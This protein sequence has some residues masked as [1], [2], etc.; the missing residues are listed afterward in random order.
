VGAVAIDE[1]GN[2][3]AG[4]STGGITGKLTGRVG[5]APLVGLGTYADNL[6]GGISATG[7]LVH[8]CFK[9]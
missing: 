8:K 3:A 6:L 9:I 2:I 7:K 4:T 5:D 1:H